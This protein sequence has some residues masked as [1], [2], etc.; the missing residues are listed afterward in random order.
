MSPPD[1]KKHACDWREYANQLEEEQKVLKEQLSAMERRL[2][3]RRSEKLKS[4]D[5]EIQQEKRR[6]DREAREAKARLKR[7]ENAVAKTKLET[8]EQFLPVPESER[9][10][11]KCGDETPS[12]VGGDNLS[13]TAPAPEKAL[14][15]LYARSIARAGAREPART[16]HG[17]QPG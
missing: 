1:D 14:E 3:G 12:Q 10:G 2:Y 8:T 16:R 6:E 11:P 4:V 5:R 17:E 9:V 13:T 15:W 7:R